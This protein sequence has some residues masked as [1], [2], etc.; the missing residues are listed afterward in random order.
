MQVWFLAE[1]FVCNF[2]SVM[3]SSKLTGGL[4]RDEGLPAFAFRLPFWAAYARNFDLIDAVEFSRTK[5]TGA[6]EATRR[7][8][9]RDDSPAEASIGPPQGALPSTLR[10]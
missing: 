8:R 7:Y 4:L 3:V 5:C 9:G 6:L 2:A 1:L 10:G